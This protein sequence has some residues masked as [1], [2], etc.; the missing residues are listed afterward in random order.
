M[1]PCGSNLVLI[2]TPVS[3]DQAEQLPG[4]KRERCRSQKEKD[5]LHLFSPLL[6]DVHTVPEQVPVLDNG[7][8]AAVFR[9]GCNGFRFR[10]NGIQMPERTG[11]RD[12]RRNPFCPACQN[13]F[14]KPDVRI[15][16]GFFQLLVLPGTDLL[17]FR[18]DDH[19]RRHAVPQQHVV[20]RVIVGTVNGLG[21]SDVIEHGPGNHQIPVQVEDLRRLFRQ[22]RQLVGRFQ[23]PGP[24]GKKA[25]VAE[26]VGTERRNVFIQHFRH[27]LPKPHPDALTLLGQGRQC[28]FP[29]NGRFRQELVRPGL[30]INLIGQDADAGGFPVL[31]G[32]HRSIDHQGE[33]PLDPVPEVQ[34]DGF[35]VVLVPDGQ[36]LVAVPGAGL[37]VLRTLNQDADL[38]LLPDFQ[39]FNVV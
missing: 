31:T 20:R 7:I 38:L 17:D 37:G 22:K 34:D 4:K 21:T 13:V 27:D 32:I 1:P 8:M 9:N 39:F 6:S 19:G 25:T 16:Q 35:V 11:F 2:I 23:N 12:G 36:P 30:V 5:R 28:L 3:P 15:I 26:W 14:Q 18:L 24:T 33:V 10:H 29:V